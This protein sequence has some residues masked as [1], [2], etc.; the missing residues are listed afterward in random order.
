MNLRGISVLLFL[1]LVNPPLS[2]Q[3]SGD[4]FTHANELYRAGKYSEASKE[5]ERI[6]KQG[7]A[8]AEVYFNLGNAYYRNEQLAHAILCYERAALLHPNDPDIEHNLKLSYLKTIDRIEPVPDMFLIQWMRAAGAW[9]SPETVKLVFMV[10]WIF[11]FGALAGMFLLLR[12]DVLR[13]LRIVFFLSLLFVLLSALMMWMQSFRET[14]KD[15]AII[16]NQ[17]VTAKSSPDEKSLDAFVIHEGVKVKL[18]DA[19]GSWI[20][21]TLADGKVGWILSEQCEKI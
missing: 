17:T 9:I 13:S 3:T 19:V 14:S 2:A 18:T 15:K 11:L 12:Q 16:T 7:V 8:S 1:W 20:K 10:A 4:V 5:Y 6:I 21:I